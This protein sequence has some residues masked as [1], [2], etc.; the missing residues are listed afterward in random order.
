MKK[1]RENQ[2]AF[3]GRR[4]RAIRRAKGWTQE[5]L[6][7]KADTSYKFIGEIER[8]QQNPSFDILEKIANALGIELFELFRFEQ[9][10]T[11]REDIEKRMAMIINAMPE[12]D[13]RLI[14]FALR[15]LYP[16]V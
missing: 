9:E 3:L 5:E 12:D 1:Q 6:G 16:Q 15:G 14:F 4:I 11:K 7:T 8:G 10:T 2:R 13:L